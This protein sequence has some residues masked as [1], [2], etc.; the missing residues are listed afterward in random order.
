VYRITKSDRYLTFFIGEIDL[1]K[2]E[3]KYINAGHYPPILYRDGKVVSLKKGCTIIGSFDRLPEIE[4]GIEK[5]TPGSVLLTFTDGLIDLRNELGQNYDE[6]ILKGFILEHHKAT[7]E[8]INHYL[9][10]SLESFAGEETFPDDVAVLCC[11]I[12]K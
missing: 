12:T 1:R 5:L 9:M 3:L 8:Q 2:K 4:E 7:A 11:K 6:D 10:D